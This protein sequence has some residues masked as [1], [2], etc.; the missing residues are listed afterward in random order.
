MRK[1]S[2]RQLSQLRLTKRIMVYKVATRYNF[3][4]NEE[5]AKNFV[6]K[7]PNQCLVIVKK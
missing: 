1:T 7:N 3:G 6:R 4:F 2:I 5:A